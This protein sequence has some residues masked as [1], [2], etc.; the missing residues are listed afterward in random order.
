ML[1]NDDLSGQFGPHSHGIMVA[2]K[3]VGL[4]YGV[5]KEASIVSWQM[6]PSAGPMELPAG[7][8]DIAKDIRLKGRQRSSIVVV[9][10]GTPKQYQRGE[11]AFRDVE[12]VM[13]FD[14]VGALFNMGVPVVCAS[15]NDADRGRPNID[16]IPAVFEDPSFPVINVGAV[17]SAGKRAEGRRG[18]WSQAGP[19]LTVSAVGAGIELQTKYNGVTEKVDGTSFGKCLWCEV[20]R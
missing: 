8:S 1:A 19:K 18:P 6:L 2:S 15:G 20:T 11:D 10:L 17:D 5:A 13:T 3:A 7:L 4:K 16:E 9:N 12:G 14:A